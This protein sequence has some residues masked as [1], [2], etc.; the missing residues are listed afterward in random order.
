MVPL[1]VS[2]SIDSDDIDSPHLHVLLGWAAQRRGAQGL[3]LLD[4]TWE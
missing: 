1:V 4:V 2:A 3:F